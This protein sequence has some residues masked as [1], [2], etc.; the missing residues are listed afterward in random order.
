MNKLES[1]FVSNFKMYLYFAH[2]EK[3]Q[4]QAEREQARAARLI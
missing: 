1:S 4:A 2:F 3:E